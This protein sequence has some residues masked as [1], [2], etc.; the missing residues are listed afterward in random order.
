VTGRVR[1][2]TDALTDRHA[3][4]GHVERPERRAAAAAGVRDAAGRNLDEVAPSSIDDAILAAIHPAAYLSSLADA[5]A[6]GGGWLDPDTYLVPGSLEAARRAAGATIDAA[7]AVADRAA[8]VAFAVV[9][10]PGHHASAQRGSGFCLF[11]NVALAVHYLRASGRAVRIAIVDWDVHHGDGTQAIFDA[12][13]ISATPRRTRPRSTPAPGAPWEPAAA[14]RSGRS[15]T[16]RSRRGRRRR[17][18]R[19]LARRAPARDRGLRTRGHP[20]LRRL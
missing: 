9:R 13:R 8:A 6:L 2:L 3:S 5:E 12:T 16:G 1:L 20:R 10:P 15:T 19:G 11:N 14:R 18:H 17:L 4:H 7:A